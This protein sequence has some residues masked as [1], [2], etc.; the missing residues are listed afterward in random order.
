MM[1]QDSRG[2]ERDEPKKSYNIETYEWWILLRC[3]N[4]FDISDNCGET[5]VINNIFKRIFWKCND[6]KTSQKVSW[7]K[8]EKWGGGYTLFTHPNI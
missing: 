3:D 6:L 5:I 1:I 2:N 8:Y 7:D 4:L